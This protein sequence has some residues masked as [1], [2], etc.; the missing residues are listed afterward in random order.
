M[1]HHDRGIAPVRARLASP[2]TGAPVARAVAALALAGALSAC[3]STGETSDTAELLLE[4]ASA[5]SAVCA[6]H[7]GIEAFSYRAGGGAP[8]LFLGAMEADCRCAAEPRGTSL[9][10][11]PLSPTREHRIE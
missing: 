1:A 7:P 8:L 9:P 5:C 10:Q 11:R 4:G 6:N 2:A 3:S